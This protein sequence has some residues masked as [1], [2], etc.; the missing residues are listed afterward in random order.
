MIDAHEERFVAVV[1]IPGAY[2]HSKVK[3]EKRKLVMKMRRKYVDF[4][5]QENPK[6]KV[7]V[8]Y[9]NGVK[10]LPFRT[11]LFHY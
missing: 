6:Y 10:M 7:I 2:L 5:C 1:D 4:L 8:L 3:H 11:I 9:K